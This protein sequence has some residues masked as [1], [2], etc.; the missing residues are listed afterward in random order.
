M[1]SSTNNDLRSSLQSVSSV[2]EVGKH[3]LPPIRALAFWIAIALPFL[4]LPLLAVGLSSQTLTGAF[5]TL[6]L[7]NAVALLVGHKHLRE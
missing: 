5:L 7:C 3:V 4:Y 2:S 6:L 1:S